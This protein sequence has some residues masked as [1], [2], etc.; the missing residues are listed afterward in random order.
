MMKLIAHRGYCR[1][2][3]ENTFVAIEEAVREGAAYVEIDLQLSADGHFV[4]YHDP[5]LKRVSGIDSRVDELLLE[6]LLEI[7]AHEPQRFGDEFSEVTILSFQQFVDL[8]AQH[9]D[10]T[11]FVEIKEDCLHHAAALDIASRLMQMTAAV[12]S[13]TVF[14][15]FS[16]ALM[17]EFALQGCKHFGVILRHWDEMASSELE[18]LKPEV[19]FCNY[20]KVPAQGSL[21]H[22]G[23]KLAL[24]EINDIQLAG[25]LYKRGAEY[26]ETFDIA[27]MLAPVEIGQ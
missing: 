5:D 21:A 20:K 23:W 9:P 13:Q 25:E 27:G 11:A 24:Y 8:L 19:V 10:L 1:F 26:I 2:Y 16:Y 14:I 12:E 15:S 6:Q 4:L 17:H 7:P 3:P 22:P 18:A